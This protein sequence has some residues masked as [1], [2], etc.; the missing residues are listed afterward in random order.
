MLRALYFC[1]AAWLSCGALAPAASVDAPEANKTMFQWSQLPDL[2]DKFGFGGP[3]VGTH[4]GALILA[5]GANF[6]NGMPWEGGSK[7]WYDSVF[8]L[9][10]PAGKWQSIGKLPR[11]LAYGVSISTDDG[12][13][14]IGGEE[15]G[16]PVADVYRLQW[17]PSG[18]QIDVTKLPPLPKSV[19]YIAGGMI[20]SV[21]YIV[22][23]TRGE[24]ADR[25]DQKHFWSLELS[26]LGAANTDQGI[27]WLQLEP[28]PGEP[29]HKTV[30]AVQSIG[31]QVKELF[32]FSGSNPRWK[33]DGN[34]DL[35]NFEQFTDAYRFT[36]KKKTWTRLA[37][38]PVLEDEREIEG[39][40]QFAANR[41]PVVAATA[42]D[43]GQSHVLVFSGSTGRYITR[44][45]E[46]RPLFPQNVLAYHTITDTW[47]EVNEMPKGVVTTTAARWREQDNL[48]VIPSGE[49][50]PG[51]RTPAVQALTL[52]SPPPE[53][54]T[55]NYSILGVY[56][57]AM[58]GVGGLFAI[59][60]KSTD[61]FFRGGQR[62]PFW[63]AGLSIFATMLSSITFV[64]LPAKAYATDW[65]Y[66]P[67]QLTIIPVAL[68]VVYLAIPFFRQIDATS[69]YEYLEKRFSRPVR[70]IGSAQFV[71]FQIGRMAIVMYLPALA[72]AAITPLTV[73]QCI[74]IM[75]VLSVIYCT[76]GGVEAVVWTDAIQTI[77]LMCGL[78]VALG[79]IFVNVD[80]GAATVYSTALAD[81]K[82]HLA[83]LDFGPNS[84]TANALWVI[85]LGM[86]FQSLYSYTS[87]QAIVQRY[88]T[89]SDE[90]GA[91]RAMWTTV[92][93]GVFG[94]LLFFVVGAALY[95]F[96]KHHPAKL[97]PIMKTD[98][99]FPLFISHELPV[100]V[101]G[102][103]VAGIF[104]AAQSTIS[105]SMNS[106]ATALVTDFCMPFDLC[107]DD[108]GYLRL[109]R[110][111]TFALGLFG[112][113]FACVLDFIDIKS[114][115]DQFMMMLGLFGGPLCGLF[116]LGMLTRR[117]NATGALMGALTGL[118]VV[119]C[120]K[121]FTPVNFFLYAMIGTVTTFVA[122]YLIS[123]VTPSADKDI[124]P[125]TIYRQR[126]LASN[127]PSSPEPLS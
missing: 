9:E 3:Y 124:L 82:M 62:V 85:L 86:F 67:A 106:T 43:V 64:A 112:T 39:K 16:T 4:N 12:L 8:V 17:D 110:I 21:V 58:V 10:S 54:G 78:L 19:S 97:D 114:M 48:I 33:E 107:K 120:V 14:L 71:M 92:W 15:D 26:Q 37:D 115:V 24:G 91:R 23:S 46:T 13:L 65:L 6:P 11:R 99:V 119:W 79:V 108:R 59:R 84:F 30:V 102:L 57:L 5:G 7:V 35:V 50:K 61:D 47:I 68:V 109:G 25:L 56:L 53:F 32:L 113:L 63:V 74:L 70:L 40:E 89:T 90:R 41:W 45:I 44:P 60:T 2:P 27:S 49:I 101:A 94:S 104:A 69:A 52:S 1:S 121:Y 77:V 122:G 76:L 87:D 125:L 20:D 66:Y 55:L 18:K 31:S 83:N 118:T 126:S 93:M 88:M 116:M 22:A 75:G 127:H 100:G 105:T 38:L 96:Y 51:V 98:A 95:V 103:V 29:R 123:L 81:G 73:I 80:G 36:P 28:W 117:A 34:P 72:M 42:I 111:F